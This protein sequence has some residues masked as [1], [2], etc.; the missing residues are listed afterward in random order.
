M[1]IL[2]LFYYNSTMGANAKELQMHMAM[3]HSLLAN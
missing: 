2:L 3:F 1:N